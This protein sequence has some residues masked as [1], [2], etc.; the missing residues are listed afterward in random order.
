M[1]NNVTIVESDNTVET[2]TRNPEY[3]YTQSTGQKRQLNLGTAKVYVKDGN[4]FLK[5]NR[6]PWI[7]LKYETYFNSPKIMGSIKASY[8]TQYGI[9]IFRYDA[10]N[11]LLFNAFLKEGSMYKINAVTII[12]IFPPEYY[13]EGSITKL[14]S[15]YGISWSLVNKI[16]DCTEIPIPKDLEETLL[17]SDGEIKNGV[18]TNFSFLIS[19]KSFETYKLTKVYVNRMYIDKNKINDPETVDKIKAAIKMYGV[20]TSQEFNVPTNEVIDKLVLTNRAV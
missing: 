13:E 8:N 9:C 19:F 12:E 15:E 5:E 10:N 4:V 2:I 18:V 16:N 1:K 11:K 20:N 17:E 3:S 14:L 6:K 7:W